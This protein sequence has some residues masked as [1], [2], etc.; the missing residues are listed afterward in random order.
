MT[1]APTRI[2]IHALGGQGGGVLANWIVDLA[3]FAGW[4]AQATSVAGVAQRTGATIYYVELAPPDGPEP[5]MALMPT[6]GDVDIVIAAELMEAGRAIARGLVT[7]D[8]TTLIASAHRVFAIGEKSAAGNGIVA[9]HK[10]LE[11]AR[12]QSARLILADFFAIAEAHDSVISASLFG[13]L[14]GSALLPFPAAAFEKTIRRFNKGVQSSLAAFH[15]GFAARDRTLHADPSEEPRSRSAAPLL[16]SAAEPI[17]R[18]GVERLLDYQGQCYADLYLKRLH[19][20]AEADRELGGAKSDWALTTSAARH[21]A[22]WMAYEDVIRVSDLKTRPAR[23]RRIGE[24]A[25]VNKRQIF[26]IT[27]YMHPRFEELCDLLPATWGEAWS[28]SLR[29]RRLTGRWFRKGRFIRTSHLSGFALLWS[30]SQLRRWRPRTFRFA[31]EQARMI[32]WLHSAINVARTD[33][34][35]AVEVLRLQRLLKG[36]G[37]T[38]ARGARNFERLLALVPQLMELSDSAARLRSLHEAALADEEGVSL[39]SAMQ[40]A[41]DEAVQHPTSLE[42]MR[43]GTARSD[44]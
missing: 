11:A 8:R 17:V 20:V 40:D 1:V 30:L 7:P 34:Q 16:P 21:L 12:S 14:A 19:A 9:P 15:A 29:L 18:L 35:L 10:V 38:Q 22:L 37:D 4:R 5:V 44:R 39:R 24:E 36:Y 23:F 33:Y 26:E 32:G 2:S 42:C 27:D 6:P 43:E 13:G 41:L 28:N 31:Q 3:E 25:R